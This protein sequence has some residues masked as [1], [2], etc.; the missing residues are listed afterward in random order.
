MANVVD[1]RKSGVD[2]YTCPRCTYRSGRNLQLQSVVRQ[3][4]TLEELYEHEVDDAKNF[5]QFLRMFRKRKYFITKYTCRR[6]KYEWENREEC[7]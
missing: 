7:K 2:R 4:K 5:I 1:F 6:C 3:R